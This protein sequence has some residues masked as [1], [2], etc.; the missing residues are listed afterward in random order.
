MMQEC[1]T[2]HYLLMGS[3]A[4]QK[5]TGHVC[6]CTMCIVPYLTRTPGGPHRVIEI[7][8]EWEVV[9]PDNVFDSHRL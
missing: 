6:G 5:L 8:E 1:L 9:E 4:N 3:N 2:P 7:T